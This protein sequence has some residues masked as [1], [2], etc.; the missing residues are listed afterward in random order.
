MS[1]NAPA[2]AP[3]GQAPCPHAEEFSALLDWELSPER[4]PTLERHIEDCAK[5]RAHYMRLAAADR[6]LGLSLGE[7]K[8]LAECLEVT[9]AD[10]DSAGAPLV[11]ELES[12]GRTERLAAIR[13]IE[14]RSAARRKKLVFLAIGVLVLAVGGLG[15]AMQPSPIQSL[16]GGAAR[17]DAYVVS[18]GAGEIRLCNGAILRTEPGTVVRFTCAW[19]W[20]KPTVELSKGRLDG[21]GAS[22]LLVVDGKPVAVPTQG[23]TWSASVTD[24]KVR[25]PAE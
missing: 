2:P 22:V 23:S 21:S 12:A 11:A 19:R 5:C 9:P 1:P 24:G 10:K 16:S 3:A 7:A 18:D 4:L 15:A 17:R 14:A 25:T 20:D 6:M 13:E 8:L